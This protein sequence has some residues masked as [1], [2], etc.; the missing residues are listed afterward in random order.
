[1][2]TVHFSEI[3]SQIS[4][5]LFTVFL[6]LPLLVFLIFIASFYSFSFFFFF[7]KLITNYSSPYCWI[8]L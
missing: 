1:M 7:F 6:L 8:V 5:F 3:P 2:I 4:D